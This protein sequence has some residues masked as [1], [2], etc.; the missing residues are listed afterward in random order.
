[1]TTTAPFLPLGKFVDLR[2]IWESDKFDSDN[3]FHYLGASLERWIS[4]LLAELGVREVPVIHATLPD[5]VYVKGR[6][7]IDR[8]ARIEPT[9]YIQGPAYIGPEAEVRHG[10]YI[11]GNAWIGRKAVVGHAT[12]VKG[13]V[14]FDDAKAGHFA[15]VG[16]SILGASVNLGAGT[17]LANL[18]LR[19][20]EVT[21]RHPDSNAILGS[22][23]RKFG[24]IMGDEAQTGC[25]AVLSPGTLLLP[26]TM[27]MPCL[28]YHGTLTSGIA[29]G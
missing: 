5:G 8:D 1:M 16:D 18:K 26:H 3:A 4:V 24:A 27:V 17:K 7:Y 13:S 14:F 23:L 2:T 20:S 6:V 15:Y 12:E 21:F 11:R 9:A 19:G 22:G 10:A 28:H 29:R 25:N